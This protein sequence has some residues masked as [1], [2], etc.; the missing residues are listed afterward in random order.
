MAFEPI[1][2]VGQGCVLPGA[3]SPA[4]LWKLVQ[5]NQ[6]AIKP[7][8]PTDFGLSRAMKAQPPYASGFIRGFDRVFDPAPFDELSL[9]LATLGPPCTWPLYA[10]HTAWQDA[11]LKPL[12]SDRIGVIT[13]NLG[14]P[15]QFK[16]AYAADIWRHG[17]SERNPLTSLNASFPTKLIARHIGANGPVISLDAACA[18]SLYA[19]EIAC[20]KLQSRQIDAALVG[21]INTADNLTLHIGFEALQALS[22][23]RQSRPF[24]RGADGLVPSEGAAALVLKRYCD[25]DD[26]DTVHGVIRAIGLSN[27]GNR[28]GLLAP[29]AEGQIEAINRAWQD[30]ELSPETIDFLECH[31]TGTPTGDTVELNAAQHCFAAKNSLPIGSLKANLGHLITVAG[32]AS[33]IKITQAMANEGLPTMPHNGPQNSALS[34]SNLSVQTQV[35]PWP[36]SA[37]PRRAGVSNFGFGGNNAH[38]ILD[39]HIP[40]RQLAPVCAVPARDEIVVINAALMAGQEHTTR[41]VLRHLMETPDTPLPPMTEVGADPLA[42]RTPPTDLQ[43]AEP[44][45]LALL[46]TVQAALTSTDL[47]NTDKTGVLTTNNVSFDFCR[48]LVRERAPESDWDAICEP[49]TTKHVLGAMANMSAN[50]VTF[51]N[52]IRGRGVSILSDGL[53]DTATLDTALT[54]LHA[55]QLDVAIVA[56]A[57]LPDDLPTQAVRTAN[58]QP[59]EGTGHAACL[60]LMRKA[61]AVAQKHTI[62]GTLSELMA[63]APNLASPIFNI[64]AAVRLAQHSATPSHRAPNLTLHRS[65]SYPQP[66]FARTDHQPM[67]S[68]TSLSAVTLPLAPPRPRPQYPSTHTAPP[69]LHKPER[70]RSGATPLARRQPVGPHWAGDEIERASTGPISDLFGPLFKQ[71]DYFARVVRLPARPLLFVDQI[72]GIDAEASIESQGTI[73]TQTDLG[74]HVWTHHAGRIRPGPLIECGQAD[75]SLISYMGADFRNQDTRV[76]RLLGCDITFHKAGLP[77]AEG[78]LTFQIEIVGHAA[79]GETRLFFFQYDAYK[80]D[81]LIFSVRNGQAGFFTTE[82]LTTA[83]GMKWDASAI[84]PP[85]P[86]ANITTPPHATSKTSFTTEEV[87]AFRNGDPF[88]CF[89]EGFERTAAHSRTPHIP[90]GKLAL[91]DHVETFEPSGG[92]WKRGYLKA[93]A[94]MPKDHWL[95][96]GHFHNDPC[97]PGTMMAEAAVQALEF[98][99]AALGL[100]ID[101]DGYI[102]A[103]LPDHTAQFICRGQVTPDADHTLSYEV[104]IDKI[105]TGDTI[106]VHAA[107]LASCD[108]RK[109]FL[110]P[111]FAIHL[112]RVWP[113]PNRLTSPQ[114]IGPATQS[115]G[116]HAALLACANGAPSE[117][118]GEMYAPFDTIGNVPRLPAP[119]YHMMSSIIDVSTAPGDRGTGASIISE[120]EIEPDAWYFGCNNGGM[121]LSVLTEI[122]LQPCGWLASHCGF[123]LDGGSAFRNLEGDGI[124]HRVLRPNDGTLTI[125]SRLAAVSKVGPMTIVGFDLSMKTADGGDVITLKTQFGFFPP[126]ALARQAGLPTTDADTEAVQCAG[127]I[128]PVL[129]YQSPE[130]IGRLRMLDE[131]DYFDPAGGRAGLGLIRARQ[132]VDPYAW[133]FKAH[134]FQDPVQPGSLGLD[135]LVQALCKAARLKGI[136]RDSSAQPIETTAAGAPIRWSYRGQVTPNSKQV[137]TLVEITDIAAQN[138]RTLITAYGSLWCDCVRIYEMSTFSVAF[139]SA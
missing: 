42:A 11:N 122:A 116:D 17:T 22:P 56:S 111:H 96:D 55:G 107:L 38:L 120:Y 105:I 28:K 1:A 85:T 61:D 121:P 45:H 106:E 78:D 16:S 15:S 113:K 70:I 127:N 12:H 9:D 40:G 48:F 33:I 110:C 24:H 125:N 137:V 66:R 2:I 21:A 90:P 14:Y 68:I 95:Y 112:R 29:S 77:Y 18:S 103:P 84:Q 128:P 36:T 80:D 139:D 82:E 102:F 62:L 94:H 138:G 54:A 75:L 71:Q 30:A 132:N 39:Q 99:A 81:E 69:A 72:L 41:G 98:H 25:I 92:P 27:D 31:A 43:A 10:A 60:I 32:L 46:Q 97:M 19:L 35:A 67:T 126:D 129:P 6:C 130:Q 63:R 49:L 13:G 51:A 74:A 20:R 88:A 117:A 100:T 8:T 37:H 34:G 108:G 53:G 50:R 101:R 134:F 87:T 115:R 93:V 104:F 3:F 47:E 23:T 7:A 57:Q 109:V 124:I 133:Y 76:Y 131:V 44:Q 91:F 64:G 119:P 58:D 114:Y 59:I 83:N 118:F 73:W 26:T 65:T 136:A 86:D 4:A 135:A 123:A 79:L 52:N 5:N 89:G